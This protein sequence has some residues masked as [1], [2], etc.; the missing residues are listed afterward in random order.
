[1]VMVSVL[2]VAHDRA[3]NITTHTPPSP[4]K[5]E[6]RLATRVGIAAPVAVTLAIA[7]GCLA[8]AVDASTGPGRQAQH[9]Y[10]G[11]TEKNFSGG[12]HTQS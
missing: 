3:M 7:A 8:I 1:M 10:I 4:R 5:S 9:A 12:T 2:S 6:R 11:E